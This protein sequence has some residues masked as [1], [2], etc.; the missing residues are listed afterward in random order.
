[1]NKFV[2]V[3]AILA[4]GVAHAASFTVATN[5]GNWAAEKWTPGG[6]NPITKA[7][8]TKDGIRAYAN[9]KLSCLIQ[10]AFYIDQRIDTLNF[11]KE[12]NDKKSTLVVNCKDSKESYLEISLVGF[13]LSY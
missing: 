9:D 10:K 8:L 1:M 6:T 7:V 3:L 12:L 2:L 11:L 13:E 5:T 4:S